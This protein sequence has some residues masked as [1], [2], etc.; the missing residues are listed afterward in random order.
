L[1]AVEGELVILA[2]ILLVMVAIVISLILVQ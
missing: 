2:A 1:E